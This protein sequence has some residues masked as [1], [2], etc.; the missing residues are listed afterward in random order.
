MIEDTKMINPILESIVS[1]EDANKGEQPQG[2]SY[3]SLAAAGLILA[4]SLSSC[5]NSKEDNKIQYKDGQM[6]L[7]FT[8]KKNFEVE[9]KNDMGALKRGT[10]YVKFDSEYEKTSTGFLADVNQDS[11]DIRSVDLKN[12]S[13]RGKTLR[14]N[15]HGMSFRKRYNNER[16]EIMEDELRQ[17]IMGK[18]RGIER[19]MRYGLTAYNEKQQDD[20]RERNLA[21][22]I[23]NKWRNFS[24]KVYEY[25]NPVAANR[26][27][28]H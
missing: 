28:R 2:R 9:I 18:S 26:N 3:L 19:Q 7:R 27:Y 25:T 15:K 20:Y 12:A 24:H 13:E 10:Y 17:L 8:G 1:R 11:W 16:L 21:S 4:S 14:S 5:Y 6:T 22:N 23:E